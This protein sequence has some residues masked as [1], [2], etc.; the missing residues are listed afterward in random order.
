MTAYGRLLPLK[1]LRPMPAFASKT[2]APAGDHETPNQ[3]DPIYTNRPLRPA[4]L[5]SGSAHNRMWLHRQTLISSDR[6]YLS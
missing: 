3:S 1:A 4:V 5:S 2:A 6:L